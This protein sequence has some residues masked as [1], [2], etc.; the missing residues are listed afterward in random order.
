MLSEKPFAVDSCSALVIKFSLMSEKQHF[1]HTFHMSPTE[2]LGSK[3][4]FADGTKA[5]Q[6]SRA[7][8][9]N[10]FVAHVSALAAEA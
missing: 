1:R 6:D 9:S 5:T 4:S 7:Q 8:T 2:D 3:A 10:M